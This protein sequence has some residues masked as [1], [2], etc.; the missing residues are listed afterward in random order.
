MA[1]TSAMACSSGYC[2]QGQLDHA[3]GVAAIGDRHRQLRA[4]GELVHVDLLGAQH[5]VVHR[6]RQRHG[7]GLLGALPPRVGSPGRRCAEADEGAAAEVRDQEAHRVRPDHGGELVGDHLDGV[8]RG[9]GF[10]PLEQRAKIGSRTIVI[11][12]G[13]NHRLSPRPLPVRPGPGH[14]P[15]GRY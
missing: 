12:H 4:V 10:D 9:R 13:L 6:A 14:C 1:A 11:A 3:D 5:A 2:G 8:G 7:L 15:C